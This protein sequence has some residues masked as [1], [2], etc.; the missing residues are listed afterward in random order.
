MAANAADTEEGGNLEMA[1]MRL[2]ILKLNY[3]AGKV[4]L[5]V[6]VC[7]QLINRI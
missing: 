4:L 7:F 3:C 2:Q 1:D 6:L 5:H